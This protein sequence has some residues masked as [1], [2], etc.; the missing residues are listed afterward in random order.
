MRSSAS[1]VDNTVANVTSAGDQAEAAVDGALSFPLST[2]DRPVIQTGSN[3]VET[4]RFAAGALLLYA[5]G[6]STFN[7]RVE[8]LNASLPSGAPNWDEVIAP[9][10]R[11][12]EQAKADLDDVA[13]QVSGM[14]GRGPNAADIEFLDERGLLPSVDIYD[15]AALQSPPVEPAPIAQVSRPGARQRLAPRSWRR[16]WRRCAHPEVTTSRIS[17]WSGTATAPRPWRSP[18]ATTTSRRTT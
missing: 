7:A 4:A 10:K 9:Q 15:A 14:L 3:I 11:E 5:T 2:A 12:Y 1:D 13:K 17:L 16:T 18:V 6:I 8:E